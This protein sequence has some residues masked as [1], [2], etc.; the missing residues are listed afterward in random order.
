MIRAGRLDTRGLRL[1]LDTVGALPDEPMPDEVRDELLERFRG[2]Q[3]DD[4]DD[5]S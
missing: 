2:W 1:T 5:S 3:Q 4:R